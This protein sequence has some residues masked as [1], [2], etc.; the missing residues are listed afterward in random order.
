MKLADSVDLVGV[1]VQQVTSDCAF[2][3]VY[4]QDGAVAVLT[5]LLWNVD[6]EFVANEEF[7]DHHAEM[8]VDVQV[9]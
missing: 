3:L 9:G 8:R 1:G 6:L 4:L 7:W 5:E 2:G